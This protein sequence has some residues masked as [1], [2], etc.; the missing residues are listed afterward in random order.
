[1]ETIKKYWDR[2]ILAVSAIGAL[3]FLISRFFVSKPRPSGEAEKLAEDLLKSDRK[4]LE[5]EKKEIE[6]EEK[7]VA[8]KV[9]SDEE[10]EKKYNK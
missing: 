7:E 5:G 6:K 3:A 9:Y 4:R 8:K 2:F 10:I 1:M